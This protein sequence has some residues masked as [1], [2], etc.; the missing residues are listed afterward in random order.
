MVRVV[1]LKNYVALDSQLRFQGQADELFM[2]CA[3]QDT[4]PLLTSR[5]KI[6][7][8][9]SKFFII[10][11]IFN[12]LLIK[13]DVSIIIVNKSLNFHC[14]VTNRSKMYARVSCNFCNSKIIELFVL[15]SLFCSLF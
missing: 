1:I 7:S 2:L 3:A 10:E 12:I 9:E 4:K 15:C 8:K 11:L 14:S 13:I 5:N 6:S